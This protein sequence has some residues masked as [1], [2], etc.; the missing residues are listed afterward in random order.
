MSTFPVV[1]RRRRRSIDR[2]GDVD[3]IS[4]VSGRYDVGSRARNEAGDA[5]GKARASVAASAVVD[6]YGRCRSTTQCTRHRSQSSVTR[7]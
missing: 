4:Y 7:G 6:I 3:D 1:V 5:G 2:H